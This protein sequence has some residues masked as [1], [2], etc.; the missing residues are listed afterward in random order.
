MAKIKFFACYFLKQYLHNFS[1]IKG[2]KEVIK[3]RDLKVLLLFLIFIE[4]SG[5]GSESIPRTTGSGSRRP[6]KKVPIR[7]RICN[8][9]INISKNKGLICVKES[10][11]PMQIRIQKR[12]MN[13]DPDP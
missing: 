7:L 3:Q 9:V 6:K 12:Q 8:T 5:A 13:A 1:K 4:G 10:L 11:V 2:H